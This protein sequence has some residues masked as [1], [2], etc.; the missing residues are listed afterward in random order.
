VLVSTH[1]LPENIAPEFGERTLE[2][3]GRDV[4]ATRNNSY[5]IWC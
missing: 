4:E 5:T 2:P 3:G 1:A